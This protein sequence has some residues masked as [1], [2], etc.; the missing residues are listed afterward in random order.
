MELHYPQKTNG[1]YILDRSQIDEIATMLLQY[2]QPSALAHTRPV[3]IDALA[4]DGLCLTVRYAA[5][6][7]GS[8]VLGL[9]AFEDVENLPCLDDMFRPT[10]ISLSAG[11]VVIHTELQGNKPRRRFTVAHECA[12]WVLHRS[13]HSPT[14]QKYAFRAQ[15]S[16]YRACRAERIERT[17]QYTFKT[18]TDWGEW[19]AD[20]LA[21]ALLM[22]L[23][24]FRSF[25][26]QII[27][28]NYHRR[29][30]LPKTNW[31]YFETIEEIADQFQVSKTAAEIRLKQL[32]YIPKGPHN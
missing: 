6:G 3:D 25:S 31:E 17:R 2:Y 16:P 12:H 10:R 27:Y 22:P 32:G 11:T 9:T 13:F 26:E 14:N 23:K 7:F 1:M 20:T 24:P 28:N 21:S 5:L 8:G 4:E 15:Q 29:Y 30:L 19:Q 18:D